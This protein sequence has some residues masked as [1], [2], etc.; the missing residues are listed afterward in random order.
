MNLEQMKKIVEGAPNEF[1]FCLVTP[2]GNLIYY[3]EQIDDLPEVCGR[4]KIAER[5]DDY[6]ILYLEDLRAE[7]A[8]H[9]PMELLD[10]DIPHG[11]IVL[12]K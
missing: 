9:E 8:K 6:Q 10:V 4:N 11:T 3:R 1:D 7:L 12:E 5:V 2:R